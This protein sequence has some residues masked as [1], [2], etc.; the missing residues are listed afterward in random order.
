M[1]FFEDRVLF[2]VALAF[3]FAIHLRWIVEN[4]RHLRLLDRIPVR[5]HVNGIRGKSTVVRMIAGAFREA[6][7]ATIAKTTGSATRII[8]EEGREIPVERTGA[9]TIIEQIDLLRDHATRNTDAIVVE[10]MA[11]RPEYQDISENRIIRSTTGVILNVRHDHEE[12]MGDTLDEIARSLSNTIPAGKRVFTAETEPAPFNTLQAEAEKRQ[13]ELVQID[14]AEISSEERERFGPFAFAENIA[15]ALKVAMAHGIDRS[16]A[17]NGIEKVADDPGASKLF[18][19]D[20]DGKTLHWVNLFS[21]N[22]T[23]S[24]DDNLEK[25]RNWVE[26]DPALFILINNREDRPDRV[27]QF[28]SHIVSDETYS[29]IILAGEL[30]EQAEQVML[31][32]A[33]KTLTVFRFDSYED[34]SIDSLVRDLFEAAGR[35]SIAIIGV[36]NIHTED[37]AV[38]CAHFETRGAENTHPDH[39]AE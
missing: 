28:A 12:Q 27:T 13:A 21:V 7:R 3:V 33:D 2:F 22:D 10:C 31:E 19:H 9:P 15:L 24:F 32:A 38:F 37:G 36:A 5:I 26:D 20:V 14:P 1:A 30:Q 35:G 16:V 23:D 39:S 4:K 6:G 29:G 25:F 8:D 34:A 17:L 11:L 18:T